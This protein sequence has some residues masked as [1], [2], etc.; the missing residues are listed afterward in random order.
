MAPAAHAS[1]QTSA[2]PGPLPPRPRAALTRRDDEHTPPDKI[3][4]VVKVAAGRAGR[5]GW[6]RGGA[7]AGVRA[8][9]GHCARQQASRGRPPSPHTHTH[10]HSWQGSQ[11]HELGHSCARPSKHL[12]HL[13]SARVPAVSGRPSRASKVLH[14]ERRAVAHWLPP[15][16]QLT[17]MGVSRS[18]SWDCPR[19]YRILRPCRGGEGG[20]S[21]PAG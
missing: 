8:G 20:G 9:I 12:R 16:P 3:E 4:A 10:T 17:S 21:L 19:P 1:A 14:R 15:L 7:G 13:R 18:P 6:R 11:S 2:Q 5:W